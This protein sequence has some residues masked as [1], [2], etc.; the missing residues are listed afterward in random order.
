MGVSQ[1]GLPIVSKMG[2]REERL[3][4]ARAAL[5]KVEAAQGN[6]PESSR[7]ESTGSI[8]SGLYHVPLGAEGLI[9]A[10][11]QTMND[12]MWGALVGISDIGWEAAVMLGLDPM[13]V[14]TI[15]DPQE[16]A[17]RALGVLVEGFDVIA[18]GD[19]K[20]TL[21]NRRALAAR[22]RRLGGLLL[23]TTPW[24]GISRPLDIAKASIRGNPL[25]QSFKTG[26][27]VAV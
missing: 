24:V 18:V 23:T 20:L 9:Y 16:K 25:V 12:D 11:T 3:R 8:R 27:D 6:R 22:I 13:R 2:Q 15:P 21:A 5:Q 10:L 19:I 1:P 26:R 14:V 7:L 17:A 4:K